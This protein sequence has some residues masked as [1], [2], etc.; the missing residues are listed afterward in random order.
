MA[1][2]QLKIL[3][4]ADLD[5]VQAHCERAI[6]TSIGNFN[7]GFGRME[8]LYDIAKVIEMLTLLRPADAVEDDRPARAKKAA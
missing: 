5:Q 6:K 8:D 4:A 7:Q 1:Q 2:I 3:T